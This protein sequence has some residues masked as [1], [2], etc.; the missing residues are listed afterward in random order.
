MTDYSRN[1]TKTLLAQIDAWLYLIIGLTL[2]FGTGIFL[3]KSFK[4]VPEGKAMVLIRKTGT[5]LRSGQIIATDKKQKG[6]QL[7]MYPEGWH[8]LNPYTWEAKIVDKIEVPEG[9]L[10]VLIRLYGAPLPKGQVLAGEGQKGILAKVLRPGR[11]TINPYAFRVELHPKISIPAGH[12][13]V[14]IRISGKEPKEPN[15]F[16]TNNG[17]RGVQKETLDEGDYYINPYIKK[18][19]P[20]D[21][22]A[23]KFEMHGQRGITFPSK[24]GFKISMDGTI[25]WYID[26]KRVA[27]VFV[28]YVDKLDSKDRVIKNIVDK[29]ILPYARGFSR[30]EGSKYLARDFIGGKTRQQ[31]QDEFLSGMKKA[32]GT[33]AIIIR[34]TLVKNVIP[35]EGIVKPIKQREIA[36]RLREKY[37]QQMEREKQQKQLS[38]QKTLQYRA[39]YQK[40]AQADVSV[41]ITKAEQRKQVEIINALKKLQYAKLR[42]QAARNDAKI[43]LAR[44][45]AK[46]KVILLKNKAN[47]EGLRKAVEA[48]GTGQAY[49]RYLFY[50]KLAGSFQTILS[51]TR[52]P[53]IRVFQ[54]LS[55]SLPTTTPSTLKQGAAHG[56]P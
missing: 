33:Q 10:G 27:E 9:Q 1:Q 12:L 19:V 49:I 21:V 50:Q 30:I 26:R 47:A 40:Q 17:E 4:S 14:V 2:L 18:V 11:H 24:D 13:G 5:P 42:L 54:D 22:R 7:K 36:I 43:I 8:F 38:I 56:K 16:I 35:P 34:S 55:K 39:K 25:E 23:H 3:S 48:F 52:G 45:Q 29:V 41:A 31:F 53:F 46:A 28:K 20:V 37:V 15:M 6:I 51:N 32:C 44:G